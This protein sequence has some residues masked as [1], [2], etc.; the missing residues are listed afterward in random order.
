MTVEISPKDEDA[1]VMIEKNLLN[2]LLHRFHEML[3]K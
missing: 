2:L 1:K 3:D